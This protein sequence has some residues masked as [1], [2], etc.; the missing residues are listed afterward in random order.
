VATH[1]WGYG[2]LKF[3][4]PGRTRELLELL[5]N[6]PPLYHLNL[7]EWQKRKPEI[8]E[9]FKFFSQT[10]RASATLPMSDFRWLT[11]DRL[12][13]RT[14]F[15]DRIELTANFSNRPFDD[16]ADGVNVP[17]HHVLK[18]EHGRPNDGGGLYPSQ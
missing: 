12:V 7:A 2:S 10:H 15:G 5:Y 1:Q 14:T 18:R 3:E 13:Q 11:G 16:D 6:V 9:H 4:D 17:P 8:V